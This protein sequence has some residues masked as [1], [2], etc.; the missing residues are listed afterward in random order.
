MTSKTVL[1]DTKITPYPTRSQDAAWSPSQVDS[2]SGLTAPRI[3]MAPGTRARRI[4]SLEHDAT[5]L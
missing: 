5:E 3:S 1:I 2:A 4:A